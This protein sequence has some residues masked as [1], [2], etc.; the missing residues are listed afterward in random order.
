MQRNLGLII[1]QVIGEF[2]LKEIT[3]VAYRSA[4]KLI[5]SFSSIQFEYVP[6][7]Q[8]NHIDALATL[9]SKIDIPNQE[10]MQE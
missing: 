6:R 1:Q 8:N 7:V 3:L 10:L 9:A 5:K 4:Q 2:T